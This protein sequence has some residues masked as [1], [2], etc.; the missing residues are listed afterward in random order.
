[1][2]MRKLGSTHSVFFLASREVRGYITATTGTPAEEITS[3]TVLI[4]SMIET[5]IQMQT[6][7]TLWANQGFSFA[8]RQSAWESARDAYKEGVIPPYRASKGL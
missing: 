3:E 8:E 7:A 1:M 6:Y 4:W 2:R 5:K